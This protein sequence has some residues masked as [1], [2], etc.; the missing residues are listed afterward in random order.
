MKHILVVDDIVDNSDLLQTFLESEGYQTDVANS[1][2]IALKKIAAHPP[3][4]ILLDV[5]MPG[6]SG[7]EV[8]QQVRHNLKLSMPILLVTGNDQA[9]MAESKVEDEDLIRKPIDF[10]RLLNRIQTLLN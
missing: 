6:M 2:A 7:Y 8:V 3:A 5:M 1:G 4:L 10:D 9:A